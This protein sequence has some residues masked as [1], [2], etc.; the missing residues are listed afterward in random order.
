MSDTTL[1]LADQIA[2]AVARLRL[3][4]GGASLL[5]KFAD[6]ETLLA[7]HSLSDTLS[8]LEALILHAEMPIPY[9]IT[10]G[11]LP[12]ADAKRLTAAYIERCAELICE[13]S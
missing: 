6:P 9:P 10:Y 8:P 2:V 3:L 4:E 12:L 7:C 11:R 13:Q 5:Y 1:D